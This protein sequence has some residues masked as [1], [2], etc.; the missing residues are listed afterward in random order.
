M[1]LWTQ[2]L[3][4]RCRRP[5][6]RWS[7]RG[8][9]PGPPTRVV[10][11]KSPGCAAPVGTHQDRRRLVRDVALAAVLGLLVAA[12][13]GLPERAALPAGLAVTGVALL[14]TRH[15]GR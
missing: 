11:D 4:G 8:S 13:V 3:K 5:T 6:P 10:T 9:A 15:R 12:L 1:R 2:Q 14:A 7:A